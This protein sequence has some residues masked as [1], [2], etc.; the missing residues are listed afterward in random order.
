[1]D[2]VEEADCGCISTRV[3]RAIV[4]RAA[5]RPDTIFWADSRRSIHE[6]RHVIIKPNPYEL[7][8]IE[9]PAPDTAVD[10]GELLAAARAVRSRNGA[11]VIVTRGASGMLASDPEWIRIPGVPVAGPTDSTG[12]GDSATAGAVLA[13]CAGATLPEAAVIANLVASITVQQLGVTGTACPEQ[14]EEV[15]RKWDRRAAN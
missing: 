11:P 14:L 15:R 7:L 12:A 2:Q 6:F 5:G 13:L 4:E 9:N 3:R 10:E 8:G 1:M